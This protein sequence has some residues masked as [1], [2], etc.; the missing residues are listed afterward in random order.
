M[1]PVA[2][3]ATSVCCALPIALVT[4]GL[5]SVMASLVGSVPWLVEL[6]RHKEWA[7][8]AAGAVLAGDCLLLYRGRAACDPGDGC[9]VTRPLGRWLRRVYWASVGL[10]LLGLASAYLSVPIVKVLDRT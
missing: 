8:A 7:F 9:H 4:L 5:G 1:A 10:Y 2:A 6:S 3:V